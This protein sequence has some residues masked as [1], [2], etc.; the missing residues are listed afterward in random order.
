MRSGDAALVPVFPGQVS[1]G[2]QSVWPLPEDFQQ[3]QPVYQLYYLLNRAN[4]FGG[5]WLTEAQRAVGLLLE[6]QEGIVHHAR[7]A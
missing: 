3:R 4:V 5:S 6:V 7:P 1:D 2:Y